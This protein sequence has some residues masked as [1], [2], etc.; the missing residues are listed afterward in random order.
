[1]IDIVDKKKDNLLDVAESD[2]CIRYKE[3]IVWDVFSAEI[4]QPCNHSDVKENK[5]KI[6]GCQQDNLKDNTNLELP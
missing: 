5:D 3:R 6:L 1:M 4:K 2:D